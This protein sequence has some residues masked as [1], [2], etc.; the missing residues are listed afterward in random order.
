M[1]NTPPKFWQRLLKWFCD[2]ELY[3]EISGDL[4]EA[5][6]DRARDQ[7]V[8]YAQRKYKRDVL[9]FFKPY[10]WKKLHLERQQSPL[11]RNYFKIALR[12][13]VK[14]KQYSVLNAAGLILGM[15]CIFL[16]LLY[17]NHEL[18]Y[19]QFHSDADNVYRVQRT[20]RSQNYAVMPFK[21]YWG[22][23]AEDQLGYLIELKKN[24]QIKN[25][26]Q[27]TSTNSPTSVPQ[28][29]I[30]KVNGERLV[31]NN[32]LW[33]NSGSEF[34]QVLDWTF[35]KG[36][37]KSALSE[38][39]SIVLTASAASKYFGS[40]WADDANLLSRYLSIDSTNYQIGGVIANVPD[41][42]HVDFD[43]IVNTPKI[44]S[45]GNYTYLRKSPDM[46]ESE[47]LAEVNNAYLRFR[48]GAA[49]NELEIGLTVERLPSIYLKSNALYELKTPG[50]IRYLW[51]FGIIGV[52][53]LVV[54]IT[55]YL[56]LTTA[57]YVGRQKEIGV[58]KVLGA[59]KSNTISQFLFETLLIAFL[60]LPLSLLLLQFTLPFFNAI[61]DINLENKVIS[62]PNLIAFAVLLP[63][64]IGLTS[65]MYPSLVLS[66][67]KAL[68]LFKGKLS[69]TR[70]GFGL[71]RTLVGFQFLLLVGLGTT[72]F[73]INQQLRFIQNKDLG[74]TQKGVISINVGGAQIYSK[75]KNALENNPK[76]LQ[77][78]SGGMPGNEMFNTLT[79][80][81]LNASAQDINDNGTHLVVDAGS[82]EVLGID[83]PTLR[84]LSKDK[85]SVFLINETAAEVLA[86]SLQIKPEQLIG[87]V[88]QMEPE[89]NNEEDGTMGI[90][91]T[92]DGII[93]DYNYFTLKEE[94][95]P[96][97]IEVQA[98]PLWTYEML[99]KLSTDDFFAT[100]DAIEK[101]YDKWHSE[102]PIQVEFLEQR[103]ASLY[104]N[105]RQIASLTVGL[106]TLAIVLSVLGLVGLVSFITKTKERE[107]G[108]RKVFGARTRQILLLLNREFF[109][110][111]ILAT[112]LATP[113]SY[114][115]ISN[116]LEVFAY[117]ITPGYFV[118]IA[119]GLLC[120]LVV[121]TAVSL[122]S[123]H[124]AGKNPAESLKNEQ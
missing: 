86:T 93:A 117:R 43:L 91:Y 89:Y 12:N 96:M 8:R 110:L 66:A 109:I 14:Y 79:Y 51:V 13:I 59:L 16:S 71:R 116:W 46:S 4:D 103:L 106:S 26:T 114:W 94:V 65:G 24:P 22:T 20:Y 31:E 97:F 15:T 2:V 33:T 19:D 41:Y 112:L 67:K 68:E 25:V 29:Y 87:E 64:V 9:K 70:S 23:A 38:K 83:H 100:I 88:F 34:F 36:S 75:M 18:G 61:M 123:Y 17:L 21:D 7:G 121:G 119:A 56:N 115:A 60:C 35:L 62:D 37:P 40:D 5:F 90:H 50:D 73:F 101:E 85:S 107:I 63:I 48:P 57:L 30:Q 92:I 32:I 84:D 28:H 105:E 108:I 78:G 69:N 10:A 77:I 76:I 39:Y 3:E 120:V 52:I 124:A 1:N 45:W 53:I 6:Y 80:K 44:P 95:N 99:F 54:T 81:M 111:A 11:L 55:N 122:Q 98:K 82:F 118:Y 49:D 102:E 47:L 74:Y 27:F 72:T 58:R 113:L 104:K 42:S